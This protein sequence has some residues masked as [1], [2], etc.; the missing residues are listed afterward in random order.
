M[1][2]QWFNTHWENYIGHQ[3]KIKQKQVVETVQIQNELSNFAPQKN[4][5]D[6]KIKCISNK[7]VSG[8]EQVSHHAC[9]LLECIQGIFEATLEKIIGYGF[10]PEKYI[11]QR[12]IREEK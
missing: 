3:D 4:V 8:D 9:I 1:L 12:A 10:V 6:N 11:K 2:P 7:K 5:A